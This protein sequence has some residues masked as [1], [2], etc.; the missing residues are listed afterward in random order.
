MR[1][2]LLHENLEFPVAASPFI[3]SLRF[4]LWSS[5]NSFA[6]TRVFTNQSEIKYHEMIYSLS[7]ASA[8]GFGREAVDK[9]LA[10]G[11]TSQGGENSFLET[12]TRAPENLILTINKPAPLNAPPSSTGQ[13]LFPTSQVL[14]CL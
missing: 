9:K 7:S 4:S 6:L 10:R 11:D 2:F 14:V 12:R 13:F 1:F 3:V 5:S 8:G